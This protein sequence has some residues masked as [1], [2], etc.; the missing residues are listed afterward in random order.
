MSR[1]PARLA[2]AL[3][4]AA[5][6]GG[7]TRE[8]I[9]YPAGWAPIAASGTDCPALQGDYRLDASASGGAT[10][11]VLE[12][13]TSGAPMAADLVS[14]GTGSA[15]RRMD[16]RL[17]PTP[18]PGSA[19][20]WRHRL[21]TLDAGRCASG[22]AVVDKHDTSDGW[23]S[24]GL[25]RDLDGNLVAERLVH[26][27]RVTRASWGRWSPVRPGPDVAPAAVVA[28][29]A[30]AS[31]PASATARPDGSP[32]IATAPASFSAPSLPLPAAPPS[33]PGALPLGEA[34]AIVLGAL[35]DGAEFLGMTPTS[36]GYLLRLTLH[37]PRGLEQLKR[38]L[39]IDGHFELQADAL[40]APASGASAAA[41]APATTP[42]NGEVALELVERG[43]R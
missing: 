13:P 1:R 31:T 40:A 26:A 28:P 36:R 21:L 8:D 14:V 32:F 25:A 22:M 19:P 43:G 2:L 9:H 15:G 10:P 5:V 24:L 30:P 33:R 37:D 34:Q 11:G 23:T 17:A 6:A 27:G 12:D 41:S 20:A 39:A 7:C 18:Q 42:A 16:V 4:M 29:V 3:A 38:K 35:P